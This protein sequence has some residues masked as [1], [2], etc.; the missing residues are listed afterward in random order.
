VQ[1]ARSTG[2]LATLPIALAY[3]SGTHLHAGEFAQVATLAEEVEALTASTG[4]PPLMYATGLLAAWRADE[5]GTAAFL[6]VGM[7][8]LTERGEGRSLGWGEYARALLGNGLGDYDKALVAAQAA[9]EH[10]DLGLVAW[11][12]VE[13]VEAA[14]RSGRPEAAAATLERLVERTRACAT[15]WA[16][17]IEARSRALLSEGPEADALYREAVDRLG[18]TRVAVHLARAHL[19]YGEWL[20]R[21]G[22]RTDAREQLRAAHDMLDRFGAGG[23]AERARRELLATGETVRKRSVP[24]QDVLTPQE[25]QVARLASDGFTNPEIGA[26][27]FI[28]P[29][30]AEYHLRKVFTKLGITSRRHLRDALTHHDRSSATR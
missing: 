2:A 27:L 15:D 14:A 3:R 24:D 11:P 12:M 30:T 29:R 18:R 28:S 8:N 5:A 22:R 26:Q 10:D 9:C 19:V 23:F 6:D 1:V 16:L 21:E 17:G 7:R 13:L 4:E 20:R 25:A